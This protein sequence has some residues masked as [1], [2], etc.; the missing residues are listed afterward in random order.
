MWNYNP[1]MLVLV[2]VHA[3]YLYDVDSSR[4]EHPH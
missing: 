1:Y 3:V 4:M 2:N